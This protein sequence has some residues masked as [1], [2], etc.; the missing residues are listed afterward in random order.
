MMMKK[1]MNIMKMK[2]KMKMMVMMMRMRMR[3]KLRTMTLYQSGAR[4]GGLAGGGS[5]RD[6]CQ[7]S[8]LKVSGFRMVLLPPYSLLKQEQLQ[9]A[10][11]SFVTSRICV[12]NVK[13]RLNG[14]QKSPWVQRARSSLLSQS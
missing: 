1:M 11:A 4:G 9:L 8:N 5:R 14:F 6:P 13:K 10:Q 12:V 2:M 7:G 3:M